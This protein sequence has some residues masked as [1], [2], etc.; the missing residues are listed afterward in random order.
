M[1]PYSLSRAERILFGTPVGAEIEVE[2]LRDGQVRRS[3]VHVD[4]DPGS[5]LERIQRTA[6]ASG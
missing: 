2:V 6:R 5:R 3:V 1:D 4:E